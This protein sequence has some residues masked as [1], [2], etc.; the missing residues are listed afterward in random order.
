MRPGAARGDQLVAHPARK[1]QV[2]DPVS[3]QMSELSAPRRNSTPPNLWGPTSTPGQ[4]PTV[5]AILC[6][7]P[8]SRSVMVSLPG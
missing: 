2:G 8:A 7:A 6:A 4:D 1:R 5:A 3:V